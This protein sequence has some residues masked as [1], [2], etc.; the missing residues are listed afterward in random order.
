V[1]IDGTVFH[2]VQIGPT[3]DLD[4]LNRTRRQLRDAGIDALVR[5]AR[6]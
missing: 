2:R 1:T 5:K 4:A 6:D 3:T